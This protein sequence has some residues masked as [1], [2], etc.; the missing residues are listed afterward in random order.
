MKGLKKLVLASAI[1]AASSSSFAMQA[2][3]EESMSA[4]TGQDGLTITLGTDISI[5]R[6]RIHDKDGLDN[7]GSA[8][9]EYNAYKVSPTTPSA[10]TGASIVIDNDGTAGHNALRVRGATIT[11]YTAGAYT[12]GAA[13]NTVLNIDAGSNAG[14]NLLHIEAALGATGVELNGTR[15]G[16]APTNGTG[17]AT[18]FL[19][20]NAGTYLNIGASTAYIDLGYQPTGNLVSMALN[21]SGISLSSLN[22][23]DNTAVTGGQ[24]QLSGINVTGAGGGN[25]TGNVAIG[26]HNTNGLR[27]TQTLNPID[28]SLSGVVLGGGAGATAS[29]GSVYIDSLSMAQNTIY[30]KGH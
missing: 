13:T 10:S 8:A 6:I 4:A 21:T 28:V 15:I 12:Y 14:N 9:T 2:M 30:I 23:I 25:I 17:T 3:D 27:I 22:I 16:V 5:G 26:V 24:I 18:Y 11:G 7:I 29:I 1:I 19:S 20:F